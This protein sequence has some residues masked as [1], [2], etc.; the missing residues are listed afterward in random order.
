VRRR[1]YHRNVA[2]VEN[3]VATADLV[4]IDESEKA[5]RR[6]MSASECDVLTDGIL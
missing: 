5:R 3:I 6:Q 2:P 4:S 1:E